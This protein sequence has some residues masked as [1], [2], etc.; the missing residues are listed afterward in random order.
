MFDRQSDSCGGA[1]INGDGVRSRYV[2]SRMPVIYD[3]LRPFNR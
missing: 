3:L 2:Y 1:Y